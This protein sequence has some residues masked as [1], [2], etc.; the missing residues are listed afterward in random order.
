MLKDIRA[1]GRELS[2]RRKYLLMI[3]VY[4][5]LTLVL[6]L[7]SFFSF[8]ILGDVSRFSLRALALILG[9]MTALEILS[10]PK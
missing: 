1:Y 6:R 9:G 5:L 8:Y 4:M 7:L 2:H 10:Q 3:G